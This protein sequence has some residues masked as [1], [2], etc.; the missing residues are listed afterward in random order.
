MHL[1]PSD[2]IKSIQGRKRGSNFDKAS[3]TTILWERQA[4]GKNVGK[5]GGGV[6]RKG[7]V[8]GYN[9]KGASIKGLQ[10]G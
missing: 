8:L 7:N 10:G 5:E 1:R 3:N 4:I 9:G 6:L 2:D